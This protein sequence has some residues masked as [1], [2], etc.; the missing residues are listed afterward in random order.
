MSQKALVIKTAK[1]LFTLTSLSIPKPG[2]GTILVKVKAVGLNPVDHF[3]QS[4]DSL[5]N[6][7]YPA[8]LGFDA[9]GDVEELGEGVQG[10][11]KGDRVYVCL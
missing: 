7:K 2:P 10:F 4:R 11:N 8:I 1:S 3:I 6:V 5:P 9:A